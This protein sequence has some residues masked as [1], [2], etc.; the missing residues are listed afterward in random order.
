MTSPID[1]IRRALRLRRAGKAEPE[2]SDESAA[3][4]GANLP[5]PVDAPHTVPPRGETPASAAVFD[6]QL[7]G[8]AGQKRG[9]R[10]GSTAIDSAAASYNRTEWSGAKDRRARK[11]GITKTEI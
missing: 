1:P 3:A 5:V 11:G 2:R 6:A 9:L 4:D 10:A 8:Q 7:L